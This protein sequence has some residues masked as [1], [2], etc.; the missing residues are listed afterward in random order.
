MEE[1]TGWQTI[2]SAWRCSGLL[3]GVWEQNVSCPSAMCGF[4]L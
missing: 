3:N 1:V 2:T 4:E